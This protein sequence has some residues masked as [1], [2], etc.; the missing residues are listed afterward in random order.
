MEIINIVFMSLNLTHP[1]ATEA[2]W[3]SLQ[4]LPFY[5]EAFGVNDSYEILD[6]AD[7]CRWENPKMGEILRLTIPPLADIEHNLCLVYQ[8]LSSEP[9]L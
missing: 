5:F 9:H 1:E 6:K 7:I 3:L 2:F 8:T 4:P